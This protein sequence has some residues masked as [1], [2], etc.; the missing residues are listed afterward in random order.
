MA[1]VA[2]GNVEPVKN[3]SAEF[4]LRWGTLIPPN[5]GVFQASKRGHHHTRKR[6]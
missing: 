1:E 6:R 3:A 5:L 4:S 2:A